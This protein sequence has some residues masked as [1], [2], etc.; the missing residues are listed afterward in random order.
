MTSWFVVYRI[1]DLRQSEELNDCHSEQEAAF[2]AGVWIG[3]NRDL[4]TEPVFIC[5]E[6]S[7]Q[8]GENR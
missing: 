4:T 7:D 1:G 5:V 8:K 3:Q 6:R 2:R